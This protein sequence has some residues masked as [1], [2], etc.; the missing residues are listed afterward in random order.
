MNS[1]NRR[2]KIRQGF[3][4][5][6]WAIIFVINQPSVIL[7]ED[8]G[9]SAS[10]SLQAASIGNEQAELLSN[11]NLEGIWSALNRVITNQPTLLALPNKTNFQ[12]AT[13]IGTLA[14]IT[15]P[16]QLDVFIYKKELS[17]KLTSRGQIGLDL[18]IWVRTRSS[19]R[20]L[21]KFELIEEIP[22]NPTRLQYKIPHRWSDFAIRGQGAMAKIFNLGKFFAA[23]R[24]YEAD[25]KGQALIELATSQKSVV[26]FLDKQGDWRQQGVRNQLAADIIRR[27]TNTSEGHSVLDFKYIFLT[28]SQQADGEGDL[29]SGQG[30]LQANDWI[31]A[32]PTYIGP[33][34]RGFVRATFQQ[35]VAAAPFSSLTAPDDF[36]EIANEEI[37]SPADQ[38]ADD[39][40]EPLSIQV[41][42]LLDPT[43]APE[44]LQ[45][46]TDQYLGGVV[47]KP[48]PTGQPLFDIFKTYQIGF[49][50]FKSQLAFAKEWVSSLGLNQSEAWRQRLSAK[51]LRPGDLFTV[52]TFY[53]KISYQVISNRDGQT[54]VNQINSDGSVNPE[55]LTLVGDIE[56]GKTL[57]VVDEIGQSMSP[58]D[59]FSV[60]YEK[61]PNKNLFNQITEPIKQFLT[62]LVAE[63]TQEGDTANSGN[64][65]SKPFLDPRNIKQM[66]AAAEKMGTVNINGLLVTFEWGRNEENGNEQ[67]KASVT[68]PGH[69]MPSAELNFERIGDRTWDMYH[70]GVDAPLRGQSILK[71]L[72]TVSEHYLTQFEAGEEVTLTASFGQEN[73]RTWLI[74]NGFTPTSPSDADQA[75]QIKKAALD[76]QD[77]QEVNRITAYAGS[78]GDAYYAPKDSD[79]LESDQFRA[80][81]R[82]TAQ[83]YSSS[84]LSRVHSVG[85]GIPSDFDSAKDY[86]VIREINESADFSQRR[87]TVLPTGS[88]ILN[89]PI[90]SDHELINKGYIISVPPFELDEK[91]FFRF[92]LGAGEQILDLTKLIES[93]QFSLNGL[94]YARTMATRMV[95]AA[96]MILE[97]DDLEFDTATPAVLSQTIHKTRISSDLEMDSFGGVCYYSSVCDPDNWGVQ[98]A[99]NGG[100]LVSYQTPVLIHEYLHTLQRWSSNEYYFNNVQFIEGLTEFLAR[101]IYYKKIGIPSPSTTYQPYVEVFSAM[102]QALLRLYQGNQAV[103][104]QFWAT[105][106]SSATPIDILE[107]KFNLGPIVAN[108]QTYNGLSELFRELP[109]DGY[110]PITSYF[111]TNLLNDFEPQDKTNVSL[112]YRGPTTLTNSIYYLNEYAKQVAEIAQIEKTLATKNIIKKFGEKLFGQPDP[113]NQSLLA[114]ESSILQF[115]KAAIEAGMDA[116]QLAAVARAARNGQPLN[117]IY[118][119]VVDWTSPL[120]TSGVVTTTQNEVLATLVNDQVS[121]MV[122]EIGL[123]DGESRLEAAKRV[124]QATDYGQGE[125]TDTVLAEAVDTAHELDELW[126]TQGVT[127]LDGLNPPVIG[128][129]TTGQK[130]RKLLVLTRAFEAAGDGR[131]VALQKAKALTDAEIVGESNRIAV[132]P[133][134]SREITSTVGDFFQNFVNRLVYG[135]PR[136]VDPVTA[137]VIDER[138][139][140]LNRLQTELAALESYVRQLEIEGADSDPTLRTAQVDIYRNLVNRIV[141]EEQ[142]A[143]RLGVETI[144]VRSQA[145]LINQPLDEYI[146]ERL[147]V[148]RQKMSLVYGDSIE[149]PDPSA[150]IRLQYENESP[151]RFPPELNAY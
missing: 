6:L 59:V 105:L 10:G 144:L 143:T 38:A 48:T 12:V 67:L 26:R 80:E 36:G 4:A 85:S 32:S 141:A 62:R 27:A 96:R 87:S 102:E 9:L 124:L 104:D 84:D 150:A 92:D 109:R 45:A 34:F 24:E 42:D 19:N 74:A 136:S 133:P 44:I 39:A 77:Y 108:G 117:E 120:A 142:R 35:R 146:S 149:G 57:S 81:F 130:V 60:L 55:P 15:E 50:E 111:L 126:K 140:S 113:A 121:P 118:F 88:Q 23:A 41:F 63:K 99:I 134:A 75:E 25:P 40:F 30:F 148:G 5:I 1:L 91:R 139:A 132:E 137:L 112:V 127:G 89:Q 114:L 17:P 147:E 20:S 131:G 107:H 21:A 65:S 145:D 61:A 54:I 18:G 82:R 110:G 128:N 100:N 93:P 2:T 119:Q 43:I 122:I 123:R 64:D 115:H 56:N 22:G 135:K 94:D 31:L 8:D 52:N 83:E 70:R 76:P 66:I 49:E 33:T 151:P 103:V 97:A 68:E 95:N 98:V 71:G 125:I 116:T 79:N 90:F 106:H 47:Q 51:D 69:I 14:G 28:P 53:R 101:K 13:V 7:A 78:D 11:N 16:I 138:D 29:Y 46:Y 72:L 37:M 129:Y 3:V 73:I 86:H 58:G